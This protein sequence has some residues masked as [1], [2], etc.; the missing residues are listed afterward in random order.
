MKKPTSTRHLH[1][2]C[3][4]ALVVTLIFSACTVGGTQGIASNRHTASATYPVITQP[5]Q[6][7]ILNRPVTYVALGASDAVGVGSSS[8]GSQGYVPLLAAHLAKGSHLINLGISGIRLHEALSKELPLALSTSPDLITIW[9]V[10]NDFI[11][12][13]T[14]DDYVHDLNI[15]L[16]QLHTKTHARLVMANLPDLTRLP[17]FANQ[18][19]GQKT[20]TRAEIAQ[21]NTGIAQL[22]ARYG[23]VLVDLF[24][25]GSQ[26]TAHP[27]YVSIDG[28]HPSPSGYVQLANLFWLAIKG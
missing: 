25:L 6:S 24:S 27:E 20:Q 12:G 7:S 18:T 26:L 16:Q 23:T 11:D 21:W 19:P 8:P 14:Y 2:L 10:A 28:L 4:T 5:T 13:V 22:A 3:V 17:A 15:L 1:L 9:L